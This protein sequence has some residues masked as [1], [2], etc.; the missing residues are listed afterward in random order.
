MMVFWKHSPKHSPRQCRAYPFLPE[1]ASRQAWRA[2][3]RRCEGIG[4]GPVIPLV[5]LERART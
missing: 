4:S 3:A 1:L 5:K 2:E